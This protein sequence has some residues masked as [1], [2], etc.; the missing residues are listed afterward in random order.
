MKKQRRKHSS[1][2]KT[3]VALKAIKGVK[4]VSQIAQEYE[5]HPVMVSNWTQ[6]LWRASIKKVWEVYPLTCPK[7][8]DEMRIISFIYQRQV[9]R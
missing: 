5:I 2:F 4:T 9:I 3:R 8:S 1:E 7:C 6:L